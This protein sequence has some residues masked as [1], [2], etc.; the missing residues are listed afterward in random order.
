MGM[1]KALIKQGIQEG[2]MVKIKEK[3]FYFYY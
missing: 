2:D 1:E 3:S